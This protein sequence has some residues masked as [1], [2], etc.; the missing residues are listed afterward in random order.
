MTTATM[1]LNVEVDRARV[2]DITVTAVG[3]PDPLQMVAQLPAV[4]VPLSSLAAAFHLRQAGA[5]TAHVQLLADAASAAELPPIL[6][7]KS[8]LRIIDGIHRVAAAKL[9]GEWSISARLIDCTDQE[10]IILAVKS[11]ALHG[12]PLSR[13]D[14]LASGQRILADHP[15]W[16]D[17]AVAG[18]TGLS[19]KAIASLRG[20]ATDESD[21]GFK[22]L[23]RDGKRRP[24]VTGEGRRR[25]EEYLSAHPDASLREVARA[26]DVS[27][28]T[29]HDVREK[30]RRGEDPRSASSRP[31]AIPAGKAAAAGKAAITGKAATVGSATGEGRSE[32]LAPPPRSLPVRPV[33]AG[34]APPAWPAVQ[35]KLTG[36]PALRY[37]ESGRLFLRWM[38][39]HSMQADEWRAFIEAIPQRW[40]NEVSRM[41]ASMSEQWQQFAEE[42][43]YKAEELKY[44]Q[45]AAS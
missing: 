5:D 26:T 42:L 11:N 20:T 10:A 9:C 37:S 13:A 22:R 44:E 18:I 21:G 29:V 14:R 23:G 12:L 43:Q 45:E 36:D 35:A 24:V 34:A 7:Q 19:A 33:P 4:R 27:I 40:L 38:A 39:T 16:S 3:L 30:I 15:D 31:S 41:A 8:S 17:R 28:G 1:T 32:R 2:R 25:A 6:L